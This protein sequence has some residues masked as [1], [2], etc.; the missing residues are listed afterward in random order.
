[1]HFIEGFITMEIL[2]LELHISELEKTLVVSLLS[3]PGSSSE[4]QLY[5]PQDSEAGPVN[6]VELK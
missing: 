5:H 2:V 1:M 4:S 3:T 6:V